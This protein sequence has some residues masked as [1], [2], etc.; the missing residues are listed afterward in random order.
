[1]RLSATRMILSWTHL[2]LAEA[3]G[4]IIN[5]TITY[6]PILSNNDGQQ[7][8][9]L[10]VIVN[11]NMTNITIEGLEDNLMYSVQ[12]SANTGAGTG[13]LSLSVFVSLYGMYI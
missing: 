9:T 2:T 8:N 4:F 10:S 11:G 12:I 5:Y 7:S 6:F 3:R 13:K 1:M